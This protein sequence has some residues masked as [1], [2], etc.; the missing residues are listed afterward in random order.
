MKKYML[1][2]RE[3]RAEIIQLYHDILVA[4]HEGR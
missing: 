1:K 2:N 4:R 3:L